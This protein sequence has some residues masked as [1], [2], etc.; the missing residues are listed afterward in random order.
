MKGSQ[1]SNK[2]WKAC[3]NWIKNQRVMLI[4]S[5]K[6]ANGVFTENVSFASPSTAAAVINGGNS[7]GQI[8][9]KNAEGTSLKDL[10]KVSK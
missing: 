3:S 2:I 9:W 4:S 5:G 6:I 7:N 1:I 8:M 10:N